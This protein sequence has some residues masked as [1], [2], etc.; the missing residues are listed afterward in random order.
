MVEFLSEGEYI[1]H[2]MMGQGG[3]LSGCVNWVSKCVGAWVDFLKLPNHFLD[4]P[5][6]P[7][8]QV[9][10]IAERPA[11]PQYRPHAF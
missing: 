7:E 5:E 1:K 2:K 4:I 10:P 11:K 9:S 8:M 3:F 6:A